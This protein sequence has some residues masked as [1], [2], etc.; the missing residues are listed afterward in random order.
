MFD[1]TFFMFMAPFLAG[2]AVFCGWMMVGFGALYP[3]I[4]IIAVVPSYVAF[5]LILEKYWMPRP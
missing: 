3:V 4:V 2:A 5:S 1:S